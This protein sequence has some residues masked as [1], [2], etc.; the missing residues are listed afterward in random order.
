MD[1]PQQV[2]LTEEVAE[3]WT[4]S[5]ARA[6]DVGYE[7]ID[8]AIQ[9]GIPKK[10]GMAPRDWVNERL[11][12]YVRLSIEARRKAVGELKAKGRSQRQIA[13]VIGVGQ[14]TVNKDQKPIERT[15]EPKESPTDAPTSPLERTSE[16]KE[17][18]T[19]RE[20]AAPD[21]ALKAKDEELAKLRKSEKEAQ[22]ALAKQKK[23]AAEA[24]KKKDAEFKKFQDE[25]NKKQSKFDEQINEVK[26]KAVKAILENRK[27]A[28][29]SMTEQERERAKKEA[30][31][32]ANEQGEKVLA[33][34]AV[35][36][37]NSIV[38]YLQNATR[39]MRE[40]IEDGGIIEDHV[41]SIDQAYI[42]FIEEFNVVRMSVE[43][44]S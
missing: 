41:Q 34:L 36:V 27:L 43:V 38:G 40:L 31:A 39:C 44:D 22:D 7:Q 18:P 10:L 4:Q 23:D 29:A 30:D 15:S 17:S 1:D 8:L 19:E 24:A 11:G 35:L 25:T 16:P 2:G 9:T 6:I 26:A 28:Q 12:G 5:I 3:K 14:Q 37:V 21:P 42:A 20:K 13:D 33:G 32:W